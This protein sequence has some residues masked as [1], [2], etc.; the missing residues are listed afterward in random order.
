M[1]APTPKIIPSMVSA[2]RSLCAARLRQSALNGFAKVHYRPTPPGPGARCARVRRP[3]RSSAITSPSA[4][5]FVTETRRRGGTQLDLDRLELAA[6]P[7]GR[8]SS[9][10]PSRRSPGE[11]RDGAVALLERDRRAHARPG[12]HDLGIGLVERERHAE[13]LHGTIR[14]IAAWRSCRLSRLFALNDAIGS[15]LDDHC[16]RLA[17]GDAA[18]VGLEDEHLGLHRRELGDLSERLPRQDGSSPTRGSSPRQ[19]RWRTRM[20]SCG[21]VTSSAARAC[22]ARPIRM[23]AFR[24]SMPRISRSARK[25]WSRTSC[26]C[27][28]NSFLSTARLSSMSR[29]DDLVA[30]EDVRIALREEACRLQLAVGHRRVATEVRLHRTRIRFGSRDPVRR[31]APVLL[32]LEQ[33]SLEIDRVEPDDRSPPERTAAPSSASQAILSGICASR[34]A[35]TGVA[36][37]A[38]RF[39][40]A[41]TSRTYG[42]FFTVIV[43]IGS[44]SLPAT[45]TAIAPARMT[46]PAATAPIV[47][48]F[49]VTIPSPLRLLRLRAGGRGRRASAPRGPRC[50]SR[51]GAPAGAERSPGR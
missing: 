23:A 5:P 50:A 36:L 37:T 26:I 47:L 15:G 9:S 46:A 2:V 34:G 48:A 38:F 22:S 39:P 45:A 25:S 11:G 28:A 7:R 42:A 44:S 51:S 16:G 1:T 40:S 14:G 21:A 8:R 49:R 10:R 13:V 3:A 30:G 24:S 19:S 6:L 43:G 4:S 17:R 27:S 18:C 32:S 31:V 41:V 33:V 35:D 12:L 20:P 29:F